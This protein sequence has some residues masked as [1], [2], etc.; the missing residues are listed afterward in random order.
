MPR[1]RADD[2]RDINMLYG[3]PGAKDETETGIELLH[4]TLRKFGME[5][6]T[7]DFLSELAAYHRLED[8]DMGRRAEAAYRRE[9]RT[10][11]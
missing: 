10:G 11:R 1:T 9:Q 3:C 6:F 8:E 5:A 7:D 4:S 2:E